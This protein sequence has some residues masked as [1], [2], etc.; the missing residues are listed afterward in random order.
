MRRILAASLLSSICLSAAAAT[1]PS[2]DVPASTPRAISTGVTSPRLVVSVPITITSDE[3]PKASL[4]PRSR[5]SQ[6]RSRRDRQPPKHP[7]RR[8]SDPTSRCP[9]DI[10]SARFPLDTGRAQQQDGA[11]RNDTDRERSALN[12]SSP[13]HHCSPVRFGTGSVTGALLPVKCSAGHFCVYSMR[14]DCRGR[15][16]QF[17]KSSPS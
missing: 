3:L 10:R 12:P 15:T 8:G 17:L 4:Q 13:P 6:V 16:D 2:V 5:R 9:S 11:H 1:G 7:R 14:F